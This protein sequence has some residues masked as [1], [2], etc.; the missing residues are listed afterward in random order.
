MPLEFECERPEVLKLAAQKYLQNIERSE[1]GFVRYLQEKRKVRIV[2]V[3]CGSLIVTVECSS[4]EIFED[5]WEDYTSGNINK[6]ANKYLVTEEILVALGLGVGVLLTTTIS[7]TKYAECMD[8]FTVSVFWLNFIPVKYIQQSFGVLMFSFIKHCKP[9]DFQYTLQV[10]NLRVYS[11][12]KTVNMLL[13][14]KV[15]SFLNSKYN[16]FF[17]CRVKICIKL[18]SR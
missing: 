13:H 15:S 3:R 8:Y 1:N 9:T 18:S 7:V 14:E 6:V 16:L 10:R 17:N 12:I 11:R 2:D 4:R 5:L